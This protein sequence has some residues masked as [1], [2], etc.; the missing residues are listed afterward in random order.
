[1]R[2]AAG[3]GSCH[4]IWGSDTMHPFLF[5]IPAFLGQN[6]LWSLGSGSQKQIP[7]ARVRPLASQWEE[8]RE[9]KKEMEGRRKGERG[10]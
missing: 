3:C 6:V 1:M 4:G 2:G 5:P 8:R 7:G 10:R 9:G